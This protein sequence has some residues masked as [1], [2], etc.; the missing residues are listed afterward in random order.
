MNFCRRKPP[1]ALDSF[2]P[3]ENDERKGIGRDENGAVMVELAI[4]IMPI[5][6]IF[7][8]TVQWCACAY[9]NLIIHHGAFVG[10]RCNAVVHPQ[11]PDSG[12]AEDCQ[13]GVNTLYDTTKFGTATVTLVAAPGKTS[14]TMMSTEVELDYKCTI[15]LG[16]VVACGASRQMHMKATAS[17][18]NQGSAYQNIWY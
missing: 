2:A 6:M 4:A 8:G 9:M 16:N 11:M 10:A 18:P 14:E 7:F 13:T 15:P 5:L 12:G 3:N 17:F 1:R